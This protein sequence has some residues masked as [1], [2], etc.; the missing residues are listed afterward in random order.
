TPEPAPEPTPTPEAQPEQPT[1]V[2]VTMP[3][4]R[5]ANL[6]QIREQARAAERR[7]REE[8]ERQRQA[9]A[10][11]TRPGPTSETA[12]R[13][14]DEISNIINIA[15]TTGATTGQGGSPT[16]GDTTGTSARLS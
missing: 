16:L 11:Q 10:Q 1:Q 15:L 4:S 5:P 12:D 7:R 3:T 13:N 14:A 2:A 6:E 8:E 9:A